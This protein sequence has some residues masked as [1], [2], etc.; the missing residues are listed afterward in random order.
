M[1]RIPLSCKLPVEEIKWNSDHLTIAVEKDYY[2][3]KQMSHLENISSPC[4][5]MR[6]VILKA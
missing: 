5:C 3:V 1:E 6:M 2:I 4:I